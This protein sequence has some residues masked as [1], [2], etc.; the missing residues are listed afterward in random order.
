MKERFPDYLHVVPDQKLYA[1]ITANASIA[2]VWPR[3]SLGAGPSSVETDEFV[4]MQQSC[5]NTA[6]HSCLVCLSRHQTSSSSTYNH[7]QSF[8]MRPSFSSLVTAAIAVAGTT[9]ALPASNST[10]TAVQR[11]ADADIPAGFLSAT[12]LGDVPH[13]FLHYSRADAPVTFSAVSGSKGELVPTLGTGGARDPYIFRNQVNG[14]V[15]AR[16]KHVGRFVETC[17]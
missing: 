13:V 17:H 10:L 16:F 15:S 9:L 11:A 5:I 7:L 12:F 1:K 4:Q 3:W 14:K 8:T 2:C 6:P